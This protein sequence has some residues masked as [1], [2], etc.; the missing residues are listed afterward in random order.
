ML[1]LETAS[2]WGYTY[3]RVGFFGLSPFYS[4]VSSNLTD[5][6]SSFRAGWDLLLFPYLSEL[7]GATCHLVDEGAPVKKGELR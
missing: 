4:Q 1:S 6:G 2:Q 3:I 5:L 7:K